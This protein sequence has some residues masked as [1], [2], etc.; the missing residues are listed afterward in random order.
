MNRVIASFA[1]GGTA[2]TTV[3]SQLAARMFAAKV[4]PDAIRSFRLSLQ[5]N[6]A[7]EGHMFELWFTAAMATTGAKYTYSED[8]AMLQW[9]QKALVFFDPKDATCIV[10]SLLK[11]TWYVST[12][13][14]Q[15]GYDIVYLDT[16]IRRREWDREHRKSLTSSAYLF[17]SCSSR[18]RT[19]TR[20]WTQDSPTCCTS[21]SMP[22]S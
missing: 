14:N 4:G 3:V 11:K 13:W 9:E 15:A 17:G 7:R 20:R 16:F 2:P 18:A 6:P 21:S 22:V 8:E 12:V 1:I 5:M 19:H 10:S